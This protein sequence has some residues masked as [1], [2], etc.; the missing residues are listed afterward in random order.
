M[1]TVNDLLAVKEEKAWKQYQGIIPTQ[2]LA[3]MYCQDLLARS[4]IHAKDLNLCRNCDES[5]AGHPPKTCDFVK[6]EL[7]EMFSRKRAENSVLFRSRVLA[8]DRSPKKIAI[9]KI[10]V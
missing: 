10:K 6:P 9:I 5:I 4:Q 3:Y 7:T 2:E 1:N 8:F